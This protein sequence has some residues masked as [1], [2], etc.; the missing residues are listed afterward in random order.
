VIARNALRRYLGPKPWWGIPIVVFGAGTAGRRFV[1][2]LRKD[3]ALGFRP[4]AILDDDPAKHC[5]AGPNGEPPVLGELSLAPR[6]AREYGIRYAAVAMP[7]VPTRQLAVILHRHAHQFPHFLLVPDFFGIASVWVTAKDVGGIFGLEIQQNLIRRVPQMVKR[8]FD[9]VLV[10]AGGTLILP[11]F[12]AVALAVKLTSSGPVF[13]GQRRIGRQG[14]EFRA[15]KFRSMVQDADDV[16]KRYLA[17][18]P[19]LADEWAQKHKLASDPRITSIGKFLRRTSLDEL[20]Q[21]WNVITGEM[22]L[23][24]PRPIVEAE[25]AR[26]AE[27]L[28]LYLKVRPGITGLWQVSGRS[29]TTYEERVGFDEYYVR[30]WSVWLDLHVLGRTVK[31]VIRAEG[32]C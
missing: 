30:N 9:L 16:L 19:E 20:P 31:T 32:A 1:N 11:L 28:D 5:A 24:G 26:Y 6:L 3:P 18:H 29:N 27:A 2:S 22:S 8:L 12:L 7:S 10:I 13:Y 17:A 25:R 15:W 23:V 14:R 21:L 4:V